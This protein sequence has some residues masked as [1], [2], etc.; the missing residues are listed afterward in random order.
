M[1]TSFTSSIAVAALLLAASHASAANVDLTGYSKGSSLIYTESSNN[2]LDGRVNAGQFTGKLDGASFQTYCVELTQEFS[3]NHNYTYSVV[4]GVA[5]W[6]AAKSADLDHLFSYFAATN[7]VTNTTT[8]A[9]AQAAVWEVI[10]ET[11]KPFSFS[12]GSFQ[13]FSFSNWSALNSFNWTA[14]MAAPV[15]VQVDE[16]HNSHNQDF[17]V[18]TPVPEPSTYALLL[19]GLGT[20]G[21]V[22]RR[23][24]R[25]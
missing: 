6:G 24:R 10:Y 19:A 9:V 12:S 22:A 11:S 16:L 20:I 23:R 18:L 2:N 7:F 8:S 3:F 17:V 15:T 4:D 21:F 13:E 25:D 1:R 14:A 5:A